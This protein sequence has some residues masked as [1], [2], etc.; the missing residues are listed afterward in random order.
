MCALR[1]FVVGITLGLSACFVWQR[2]TTQATHYFWDSN[3]TSEPTHAPVA[4]TSIHAL[5]TFNHLYTSG[6]SK[7]KLEEATLIGE[8]SSYASDAPPDPPCVKAGHPATPAIKP[9]STERVKNVNMSKD[10]TVAFEW[11]FAS[12]VS[13]SPRQTRTY[14]TYPEY[15]VPGHSSPDR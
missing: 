1:A 11:E 6:T 2:T 4:C 12:A 15:I 10:G 8:S 5:Q 3:Q 9:G 14:Y 7:D 13:S